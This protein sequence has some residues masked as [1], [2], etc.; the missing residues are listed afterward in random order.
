MTRKQEAR[1]RHFKHLR[2]KYFLPQGRIR[3]VGLGALG[4]PE[5][6]RYRAARLHCNEQIRPGQGRVSV[7]ARNAGFEFALNTPFVV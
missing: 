4:S 3:E 7:I 5:A 1:P 6:T 2:Q